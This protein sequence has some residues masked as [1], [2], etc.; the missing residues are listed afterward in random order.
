M[1][2]K[3]SKIQREIATQVKNIKKCVPINDLYFAMQNGDY[4]PIPIK[5]KYESLVLNQLICSAKI[6]NYSTLSK[7]S[8]KSYA[9]MSDTDLKNAYNIV[10]GFC[11]VKSSFKSNLYGVLEH[12]IS[13][14]ECT[15]LD[16]FKKITYAKGKKLDKNGVIEFLLAVAALSPF[17]NCFKHE[18]N[19]E[20]TILSFLK[21]S[22]DCL[23][24]QGKLSLEKIVETVSEPTNKISSKCK[25]WEKLFY[26]PREDVLLFPHT[27]KVILKNLDKELSARKEIHNNVI[28][29][30]SSDEMEFDKLITKLK[31]IKQNMKNEQLKE[32]SNNNKIWIIDMYKGHCSYFNTTL[33]Q[34][35]NHHTMIKVYDKASNTYKLLS[36]N[37]YLEALSLISEL[38]AQF[39][40][41]G[42]VI[43]FPWPE[44]QHYLYRGVSLSGFLHTVVGLKSEYKELDKNLDIEN[45]NHELLSKFC[46]YLKSEE[47][48]LKD[49]SF[50]STS[51]DK[52]IAESFMDSNWNVM[53]TINIPQNLNETQLKKFLFL[54][55][56][57]D[58]ILSFEQE[59]LLR[60]NLKLKIKDCTYSD[61][62]L[63]VSVEPIV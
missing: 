22:S 62:V 40:N 24:E 44:G 56:D 55:Y 3:T 33:R 14:P 4:K 47:I 28:K 61:K 30:F 46:E 41:L 36:E 53:L 9:E 31:I 48:Q 39:D 57:K 7:Q 12:E 60:P 26:F 20:N 13:L 29:K 45:Q 49:K 1:P 6:T 50:C 27:V 54:D 17:L 38:L 5:S 23:N 10:N 16:L 63:S 34:F 58:E 8:Y 43:E 25:E 11:S 21:K 15:N 59:V 18:K 42:P 2:Q 32:S 52:E 19:I 35:G 51:L 37:K